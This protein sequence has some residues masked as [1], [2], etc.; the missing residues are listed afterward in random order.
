MSGRAARGAFS[1]KLITVRLSVGAADQHEPAAADIAA[2][3]IDDGQRVADRDRGID[4]IAAG[5][6][7]LG[8]DL[9]R[10]DA[11]R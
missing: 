11:A 4:R 7:D 2:A 10:R 8:P 5:F 1:R 6:Q 9:A 3:R